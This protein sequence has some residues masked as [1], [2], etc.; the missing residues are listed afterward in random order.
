[1]RVNTDY[2]LGTKVYVLFHKLIH[3]GRVVAVKS[4]AVP[5]NQK[6]ENT[7]KRVKTVVKYDVRIR[8]KGEYDILH[9]LSRSRVFD[10]LDALLDTLR[11]T[12]VPEEEL[13]EVDE[14]ELAPL[15]QY[16]DEEVCDENCKGCSCYDEE[17]N[18]CKI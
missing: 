2:S 1:M 4:R 9:D 6:K 3:E 16:N 13:L 12:V 5:V 15:G 11:Y 10:Y 14:D 17:N 7:R 8:E 18:K